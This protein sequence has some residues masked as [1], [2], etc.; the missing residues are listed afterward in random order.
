MTIIAD[1]FLLLTK[2]KAAFVAVPKIFY[3]F[4]YIWNGFVWAFNKINIFKKTV[5]EVVDVVETIAPTVGF[6]E[7]VKNVITPRAKLTYWLGDEQVIV[8][9]TGFRQKDKNTLIY[10]ALDTDRQVMVCGS[11]PIEYRLE[12]LK[13]GDPI[14]ATEIQQNQYH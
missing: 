2:I 13:A 5:K 3:I 6:F 8:Y 1:L 14:E 7:K 9:V 11:E 12:E 10:K 4:V